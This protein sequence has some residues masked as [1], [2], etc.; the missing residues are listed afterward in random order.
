MFKNIRRHHNIILIIFYFHQIGSIRNK[1]ILIIF[2]AFRHTDISIKNLVLQKF[3]KIFLGIGSHFK[4]FKFLYLLIRFYLF[5][6]YTYCF[7]SLIL[8][9]CYLHFLFLRLTA[10]LSIHVPNKTV[11]LK[12]IHS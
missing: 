9:K 7:I 3:P 8:I 11:P 2:K 6:N 12:C 5:Y 4:D 10:L 1:K